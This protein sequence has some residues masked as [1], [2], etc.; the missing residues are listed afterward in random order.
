MGARL[1]GGPPGIPGLWEAAS[2]ELAEDTGTESLVP[3]EGFVLWDFTG[4]A[5]RR[6]CAHHT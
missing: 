4:D 5:V 6:R 3:S 2:T 1:R